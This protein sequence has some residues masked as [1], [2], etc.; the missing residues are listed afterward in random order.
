MGSGNNCG[1]S[2]AISSHRLLTAGIAYFALSAI[3]SI[4][5]SLG[6]ATTRLDFLYILRGR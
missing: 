6:K 5:T 1:C 4:L 2:V 3:L